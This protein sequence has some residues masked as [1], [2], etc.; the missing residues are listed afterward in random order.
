MCRNHSPNKQDTRTPHAC[1]KPDVPNTC[2]SYAWV[3]LPCRCRL[4][5]PR[6][7]R[8]TKVNTGWLAGLRGHASPSPAL[9]NLKHEVRHC[10]SSAS[11]RANI[12]YPTTSPA[13]SPA[14]PTPRH[15]TSIPPSLSPSLPHNNHAFHHQQQRT[16]PHCQ[17]PRASKHCSGD[18]LDS[19]ATTHTTAKMTAHSPQMH[20]PSA[21]P[22]RPKGMFA[23]LLA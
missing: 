19:S 15:Y 9:V 18:T 13:H 2:P 23:C 14:Q 12:T 22:E 1:D 8:Q 3:R 21:H 16:T 10:T 17:P 20:S 6:H 5:I 4:P 7:P 11:N